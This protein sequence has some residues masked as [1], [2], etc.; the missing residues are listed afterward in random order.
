MTEVSW[1]EVNK[2]RGAP[3]GVTCGRRQPTSRLCY[4]EWL[5]G[6]RAHIPQSGDRGV[7]APDDKELEDTSLLEHVSYGP[8]LTSQKN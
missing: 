6:A 2:C 1:E 3:R 8:G 4:D 7:Y 5:R